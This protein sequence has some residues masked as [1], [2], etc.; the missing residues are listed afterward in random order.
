MGDLQQK[1]ET[2][3]TKLQDLEELRTKIRI[4]TS[5]E[6]QHVANSFAGNMLRVIDLGKL[7]GQMFLRGWVGNS[8]AAKR[9][10][11][12]GSIDWAG[13]DEVERAAQFE[14][15]LRGHA[16]Q[17][18]E[19][20][21]SPIDLV[22]GRF[23][24]EIE[25]YADFQN[26]SELTALMSAM[27][28]GAWTAF[29]VLAEDLWVAL[30]NARPRLGLVALN[31][32]LTAEDSPEKKREKRDVKYQ[33]PVHVLQEYAYDLTNHMGDLL[34]TRWNF[35]KPEHT[36]DAYNRVFKDLKAELGS[37]FND[38]DIKGLAAI[39]NVVVHN[40]GIADSVFVA[41]VENHPKLNGIATKQPVP[42]DG[43]L[44]VHFVQASANKSLELIVHINGWLSGHKE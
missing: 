2:S 12:E 37:V 14:D 39:R 11:N 13:L 34:R 20:Y 41:L 5:P 10:A 18:V 36:A 27:I 25:K 26:P 42:V 35:S 24:I 16:K 1:G 32:E 30:L 3:Y 29:E 15:V 40:A 22:G 38:K 23:P 6:I 44:V 4:A 31:A 7:P 33:L 28:V 19:F 9:A 8:I 21:S 43:S 17:S